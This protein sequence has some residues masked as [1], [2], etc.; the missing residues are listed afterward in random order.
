[1]GS[2]WSWWTAARG[3]GFPMP[4]FNVLVA[5]IKHVC[6]LTVFGVQFIA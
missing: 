1:M 4:V 3:S 5:G 2:L 6:I